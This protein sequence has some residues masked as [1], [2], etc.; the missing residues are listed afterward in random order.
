VA[1]ADTAVLYMA[2]GDA[3]G[4]KRALI[5][6]GGRPETPVAVAESVSLE[7]SDMRRGT[8]QEL[9]RL[10]CGSSGGPVLILLG[11]VYAEALDVTR[12]A[13]RQ[14]AAC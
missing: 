10:A 11:K 8:L 2:A 13:P 14:A 5:A 3:D 9:P 7:A 1:A 4:V 6:A 12:A